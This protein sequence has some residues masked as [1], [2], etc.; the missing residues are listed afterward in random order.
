[1]KFQPEVFEFGQR[2]GFVELEQE[3][4]EEA[5]VWVFYWAGIFLQANLVFVKLRRIHFQNPRCK[6]HE[7]HYD[8]LQKMIL[9]GDN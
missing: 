2:E 4:Q 6:H 5:V 1:M 7:C 3:Q 8:P 9:T